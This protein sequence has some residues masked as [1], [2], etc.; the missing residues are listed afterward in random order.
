V[1]R[2]EVPTVFL[3]L[4]PQHISAVHRA[5]VQVTSLDAG[6][7]ERVISRSLEEADAWHYFALRIPV[8]SPG[9]YR[10]EMTTGVDHGCFDVAFTT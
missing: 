7:T 1:P 3:Y 9:S 10:L 8:R 4:I 5:T 6:T 2:A